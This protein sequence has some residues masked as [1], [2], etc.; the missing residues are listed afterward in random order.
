MSLRV[1]KPNNSEH[2]TK[3]IIKFE[4]YESA[5]SAQLHELPKTKLELDNQLKI[6]G[7]FQILANK[8]ENLLERLKLDLSKKTLLLKDYEKIIAQ[9]TET[10]E[11]QLMQIAN[12]SKG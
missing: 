2:I 4:T 1:N 7:D 9:S 8:Q 3:L 12:Q 6:N 5:L 10:I 11:N